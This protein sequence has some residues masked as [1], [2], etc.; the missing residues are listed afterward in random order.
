MAI[1]VGRMILLFFVSSW[2]IIH[3]GMKPV[4]GGRPPRERRVVRVAVAIRGVLFHVWDRDKV[5]VDIVELRNRNM[6]RVSIM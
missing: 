4:K 3:L 5:V 1:R 6:V 2:M